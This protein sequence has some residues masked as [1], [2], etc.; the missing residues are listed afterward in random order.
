MTKAAGKEGRP[1][2][3]SSQGLTSMMM[4]DFV[5]FAFSAPRFFAA[6]MTASFS[7]LAAFSSCC[8]QQQHRGRS[9]NALY[10]CPYTSMSP[11]VGHEA[12][13]QSADVKVKWAPTCTQ[14]HA[15]QAA[16]LLS[17]A[18]ATAYAGHREDREQSRHALL[19]TESLTIPYRAPILIKDCATAF[20]FNRYALVSD[21]TSAHLCQLAEEVQVLVAVIAV[22]IV[23]GHRGLG[24]RGGGGR[25]RGRSRLGCCS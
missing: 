14:A 7:A 12:L 19:A 23:G 11:T 2:V 9:G 16:M 8:E 1:P 25:S 24:G 18:L 3:V 17:H 15:C 21:D 20:F 4:S 6:A 10:C 5:S 22:V 13:L